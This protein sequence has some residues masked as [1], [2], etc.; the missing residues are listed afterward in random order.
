M[1]TKLKEESPEEEFITIIQL[2]Y[3]SDLAVLH[4][5]LILEDEE[6]Q[7]KRLRTLRSFITSYPSIYNAFTA[8]TLVTNP[9]YYIANEIVIRYK[10]QFLI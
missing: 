1:D 6:E 7:H 8:R 3:D 2:L 9:N 5:V 10:K 4:D